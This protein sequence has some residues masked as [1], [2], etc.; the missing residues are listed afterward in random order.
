M[1]QIYSKLKQFY[2][3]YHL[4]KLWKLNIEIVKLEIEKNRNS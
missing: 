3:N 1:G 2:E 4:Y